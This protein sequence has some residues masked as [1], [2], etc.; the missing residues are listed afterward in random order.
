MC[1]LLTPY[2]DLQKIPLSKT[3]FPW[4][5]DGTYL[6]GDN[7]KYC[8]GYATATLFDVVEAASLPLATL[9]QQAKFYTPTWACTLAKDTTANTFTDSRYA[10]G[11]ALDFGMLWKQHVFLTS[12]RNKIK[13]GPNVQELLDILLL[14]AT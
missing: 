13:N 14:P 9:A 2:D 12:S 1:H 10:F 11:L 8:A 7:G 3:D 4:F 6:K 5:T